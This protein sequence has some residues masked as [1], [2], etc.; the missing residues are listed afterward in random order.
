MSCPLN[1]LQIILVAATANCT[2]TSQVDQSQLFPPLKDTNGTNGITLA[3][4]LQYPVSRGSVHIRTANAK[5]QPA[6]DP[7]YFR[8]EADM[9]QLVVGMR[10]LDQLSQ[11][12]PLKSKLGKRLH[13]RADL[14]LSKT[15]DCRQ[16]I[17]DWYMSEYH[18]CGS[19][20][21]GDAL[22]SKLKVKGAEGLRVV[23]ASCF[24]GNGKSCAF[25]SSSLLTTSSQWQHNGFSLR[26]SRESS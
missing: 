15:E 17:L 2:E 16:G 22:D 1:I 20:A 24:A 26:F 5:D 13:P 12:E 18:L 21:A 6:I 19:V 3:C 4:C 9:D 14:D 7:G 25:C 10:F 11:T 23:D 8:H